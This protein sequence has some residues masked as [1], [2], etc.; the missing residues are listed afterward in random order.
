MTE[1]IVVAIITGLCAAVVAI[2][3]Q[4]GLLRKSRAQDAAE[5]ARHDERTDQRLQRIERKLDEHNGY[6]ERLGEVQ[7]DIAVIKA[8]LKNLRE[9]TQQ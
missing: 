6:A 3:G 7:T 8:D 4:W 2:I 9:R 5:R 1:G